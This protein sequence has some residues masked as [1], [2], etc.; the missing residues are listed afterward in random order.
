MVMG[1]SSPQPAQKPMRECRMA[2]EGRT[3]GARKVPVFDL[4][5]TDSRSGSLA[6]RVTPLFPPPREGADLSG[7]FD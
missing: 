6:R 2:G 7:F 5:R 4:Q 1:E 3:S